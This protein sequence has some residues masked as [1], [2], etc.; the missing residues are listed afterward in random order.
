MGGCYTQQWFTNDNKNNNND[1]D[2]D[3]DNGKGGSTKID[4]NE[5]INQILPP[6][7]PTIL[8]VRKPLSVVTQDGL[9]LRFTKDDNTL[10]C[11]NIRT[12]HHSKI[13]LKQRAIG[14]DGL[15]SRPDR[16]VALN[17]GWI[18]LVTWDPNCH[19]PDTNGSFQLLNPHTGDSI[20]T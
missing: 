3:N 5:V 20:L 11:Y 17:N 10:Q 16:M 6:V 13:P 9:W 2:D 1:D 19:V 18:L 7:L 8:D 15:Y 12:R 4:H 14:F